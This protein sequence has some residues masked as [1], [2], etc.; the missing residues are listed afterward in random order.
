MDRFFPEIKEN[1]QV[2]EVHGSQDQNDKADLYAQLFYHRLYIDDTVG[3]LQSVHRITNIDK[4]KA[5]KQKII[6]TVCQFLVTMKD[7]DQ[8]YF[9]VLKQCSCHPDGKAN[10]DH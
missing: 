2:K 7:I 6:Y 4:V 5:N 9:S 1:V 3:Y 8:E 10:G